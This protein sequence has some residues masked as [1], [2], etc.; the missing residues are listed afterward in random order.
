M[1][2]VVPDQLRISEGWVRC[3]Q[4]AE[5]FNASQHLLSTDPP[6]P[7]VHPP[8][9]APVTAAA[10]ELVRT[11]PPKPPPR[12]ALP[13]PRTFGA[14]PGHKPDTQG[15]D[16]TPTE[17][18]WTDPTVTPEPATET[19]TPPEAPPREHAPAPITD[20]APVAAPREREPDPDVS[21]LRA[22][23]G[24]A[25]FWS[26]RS[27]RIVLFLLAIALGATLV[28]QVL[29]RE[30]NHIAQLQ[31]AVRPMLTAL[32]AVAGCALGPLQQI[33]SIVIDSSSFGRLRA[34]NYRLAF[35]LRNTAPVNL[36]MPAIEL[37]LTDSQDQAL[38]RRVILPS[39]FGAPAPAL[40]ADSDWNGTLTLNVRPST[41]SERIAGYRLLAF[42]P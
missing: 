16:Q 42:Y 40:A 28:A 2:K 7:P 10:T 23:A 12:E 1:F 24:D 4:C 36:A 35:S 29:V 6:H 9:P 17:P 8:V 30:R 18:R 41:G 37:S 38:I 21:F 5:I 39:E 15:L 19:Y 14:S 26:R 31:P 13:E 11:P 34:D 33:E 22:G 32:C 20:P 25:S 3:G 27:V